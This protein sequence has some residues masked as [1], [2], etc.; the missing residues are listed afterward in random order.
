MAHQR[1]PEIKQLVIKLTQK[2]YRQLEKEAQARRMNI[3]EYV[4]F[5]LGEATLK[6]PLTKEDYGIIAN[7]IKSQRERLD[8]QSSRKRSADA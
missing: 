1:S 6:T 4:R 3:S 5:L 2:L 8:L 7:R